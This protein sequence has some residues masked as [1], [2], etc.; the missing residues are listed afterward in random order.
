MASCLRREALLLRRKTPPPGHDLGSR[1]GNSPHVSE[2]SPTCEGLGAYL[3][4][5]RLAAGVQHEAGD[6]RVLVLMGE[7]L[8]CV[9][10]LVLQLKH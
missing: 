3:L 7:E 6:E 2:K 1:K 5:A 8:H 4:E 9:A 10:V